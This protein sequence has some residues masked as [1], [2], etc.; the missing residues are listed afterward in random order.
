MPPSVITV[1]GAQ[2][3]P[4][5]HPVRASAGVRSEGSRRDCVTQTRAL[6]SHPALACGCDGNRRDSSLRSE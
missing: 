1:T 4:N 2:H 6:R 5:R 3:Q